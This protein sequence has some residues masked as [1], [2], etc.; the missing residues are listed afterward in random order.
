MSVH[1]IH[2]L[3]DF[4]PPDDAGA[5]VEALVNSI[6]PLLAHKHPS[7][8]GGTL[9]ALVATW[10]AA[11]TAGKETHRFRKIQFKDLSGYIWEMV[12]LEE[13]EI[14]DNLGSSDVMGATL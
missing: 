4:S 7:V 5:Q 10:L 11:H 2:N 12:A 3:A 8:V 6:R 14:M 9:G 1:P 13:K